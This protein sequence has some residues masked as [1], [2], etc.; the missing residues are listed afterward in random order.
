[1]IWSTKKRW[2]YILWEGDVLLVAACLKIATRFICVYICWFRILLNATWARLFRYI[3]RDDVEVCNWSS[4]WACIASRVSRNLLSS[5]CASRRLRRGHYTASVNTA[6]KRDKLVCTT[7][8]CVLYVFVFTSKASHG[9]I[10]IYTRKQW[11]TC[12]SIANTRQYFAI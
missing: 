4:K 7:Y 10:L 8:T 3:V 12:N 11:K 9:S 5:S 6:T 1:M 2:I